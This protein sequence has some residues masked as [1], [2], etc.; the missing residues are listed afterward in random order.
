MTE[1]VLSVTGLTKAFGGLTA[2]DGVSLTL[3][4]GEIHA[5]IGPNGAGKST[6]I[7]QIAGDL[8]RMQ[9]E[10]GVDEADIGRILLQRFQQGIEIH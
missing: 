7:R 10:V 5:L 2:T 6:L 1:P 3:R 9:V 4:P 8:A